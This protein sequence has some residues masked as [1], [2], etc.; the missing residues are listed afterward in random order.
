MG[1]D[2]QPLVAPDPQTGLFADEEAERARRLEECK[3][4]IR[5]RSGFTALLSGSALQLADR[6]ER[7]RE[8]FRL[9]TP[10]L[11]R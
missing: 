8:N 3:D 10:C 9:R 11:T 5:R 7:D 6:L 2:L 4:A 1:V